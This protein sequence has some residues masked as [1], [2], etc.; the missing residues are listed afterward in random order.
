[1]KCP[2]CGNNERFCVEHLA[3]VEWVWD[4]T[5]NDYLFGIMD[6]GEPHGASEASTTCMGCMFRASLER[7][8]E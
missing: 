6:P 8:E 1:M 5:V 4:R 3:S 7:F 2:Q